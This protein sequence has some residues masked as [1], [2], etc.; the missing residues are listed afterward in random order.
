MKNYVL[1]ICCVCFVL[2]CGSAQARE[3]HKNID[4]SIGFQ[5]Y[6]H[7]YKEPGLMKN[8]GFFYGISYSV[9]HEKENTLFGLEGLLAY[10]QVDYSSVSTGNSDDIDDICADN[11]IILG[12]AV[13]N[14]QKTR[15]TPFV[16][17]AYRFLQDDS[18]YQRTTTNHIGYLRES[19]YFY[20]PVGVKIK[21]QYANGWS[22]M[23][24]L[25]YDY[26]WFGRQESELGYLAG[27][28]DMSN[29]QEDG[30][31][32]RLSLT[33]EKKTLQTGYSFQVFYRFWDIDTSDI[34]TDRFGNIGVEPAN[35]TSE[36]GFNFSIL[37]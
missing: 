24:E 29:D 16:G 34:D 18:K 28:E 7:E 10:G 6:Y 3:N 12:Y 21:I 31:G 23:P 19:N 35:E 11:R 17:V 5:S 25:E 30:Y 8:E 33:L 20:S 13:Y 36:Y 4:V 9:F 15:I 26:F 22:L 14:D 27:I 32:Y 1:I 37:F 2:L